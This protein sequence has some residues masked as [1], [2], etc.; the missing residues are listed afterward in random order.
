M[1]Y[2]LVKFKEMILNMEWLI[3]VRQEEK[4]KVVFQKKNSTAQRLK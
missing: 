4:L 2:D 3:F 1:D